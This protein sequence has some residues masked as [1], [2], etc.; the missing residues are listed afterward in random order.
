MEKDGINKL[1]IRNF[2]IQRDFAEF[3]TRW[4][5]GICPPIASLPKNGAVIND[6]DLMGFLAM[7]DC[8][9]AI[10]TWYEFAEISSRKKYIS[11]NIYIEWCKQMAVKNS[12]KFIFC[13]SNKSGIIRILES[14]KFHE[15]ERGHYAL[16]VVYG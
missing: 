7:T 11:F 1:P 12:K 13:F 9:F 16:E 4:D 10:M 15:I 6:G 5:N 2:D 3:A 14:H 8:D